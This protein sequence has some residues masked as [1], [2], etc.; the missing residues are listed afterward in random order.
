MIKKAGRCVKVETV[1]TDRMPF[2]TSCVFISISVNRSHAIF[3]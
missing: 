1:K 2:T 3:I